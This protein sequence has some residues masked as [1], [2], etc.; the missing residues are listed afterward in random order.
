HAFSTFFSRSPKCMAVLD[1][2]IKVRLPKGSP[3]TWDFNT[4]CIETV[5]IYKNDISYCLEKIIETEEDS[6]IISQALGLKAVL[7][8]D[9]FLFWLN[10][11]HLVMP[12]CDILFDQLHQHN[13]NVA[14]VKNCMD[15]FKTAIE[16]IRGKV[17]NELS[18]EDPLCTTDNRKRQRT[19]EDSNHRVALEVCDII[20]SEMSHRFSFSDHLIISEL[21][22]NDR[23]ATYQIT[24]PENI[25]TLVKKDFPFI[26]HFQLKTELQIIY[27]RDD[28]HESSGAVAILQLFFNNNLNETFSETV[29][30]LT[31]LCTLPMATVESDRCFSTL[32]RVKSFLR[33][34]IDREKLSAL[35]MLSIEKSLICS[36]INYNERVINHFADSKVRSM[37]LK[38]KSI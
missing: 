35:S 11:F 33:S 4:N 27:D 20:M 26:N 30:L 23:F 21:F 37:T 14:S 16:T 38:F 5:S 1:E 13:I 19:S 10:F 32:K 28:F 6:H 9:D 15:S 25:L 24:F 18:L 22:N 34:T 12:Y 2:I 31:I 8:N 29:K 7:E 17:L 3:T 36:I